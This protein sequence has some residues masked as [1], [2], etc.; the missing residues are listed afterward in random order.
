MNKQVYN[1]HLILL[2]HSISYIEKLREKISEKEELMNELTRIR[3]EFFQLE[4][5]VVHHDTKNTKL[6]ILFYFVHK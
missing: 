3:E 2:Y 6:C 1:R 4:M 5:K